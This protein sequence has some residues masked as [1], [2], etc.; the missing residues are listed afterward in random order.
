MGIYYGD[1]PVGGGSGKAEWDKIEG[2]PFGE[3]K[4]EPICICEYNDNLQYNIDSET[5][6]EW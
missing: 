3:D 1:L 5:Q 4:I 2:K 6:E